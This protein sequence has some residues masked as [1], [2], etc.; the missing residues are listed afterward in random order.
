MKEQ[1]KMAELA[2][3]GTRASSAPPTNQK[4]KRDMSFAPLSAA[5]I[6]EGGGKV[7][8]KSVSQRKNE[9]VDYGTCCLLI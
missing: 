7:D 2:K 1:G 3:Q 5:Q 6:K 8:A 9:P 4:F